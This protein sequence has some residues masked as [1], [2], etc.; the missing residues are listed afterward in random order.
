MSKRKITLKAI[1]EQAGLSIASVS[2][3]IHTPH[4]TQRE[5][6][7]RVNQAITELDFDAKNLLKRYQTNAK[8]QIILILDNQMIT[9][10][11][12]NQGIENQ[13]KIKGYKILYLRFI[14]FTESEIQQIINYTINF[15][16][17]GILII[18]NSPHLNNLLQMQ[19]ALPPIVLINQF[20]LKFPCVYFD[21][22]SIGYQA[23][24]YLIGLGHKQIAILLANKDESDV[25]QLYSGHKQALARANIAI[26]HALIAYQSVSYL[27]SKEAVKAMLNSTKPPT[28]IICT[29][30]FGLNHFDYEK[31][32]PKDQ[33]SYF[34]NAQSTICGVIDQC[35]TMNIDIPENLSLLQFMPD[36]NYKLYYPLNHI[37]AMYKPLFTM[38]EEAFQLLFA[39]V[40]GDHSIRQAK[41]IDSELIIRH[42][43]RKIK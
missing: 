9:N 15:Q 27:R 26:N 10:S 35:R 11:L 36:K 32:M 3:V 38:G 21:H 23:T 33:H 24:Q 25:Y 16:L 22:L 29:D 19:H 42:S 7:N 1:A 40:N 17:D 18:N 43:T 31:D 2:R 8:S 28:A 34:I 37:C 20:S 4:L 5:T 13:A 39:I 30:Q 6:Q 12:I 14:Y 41:L